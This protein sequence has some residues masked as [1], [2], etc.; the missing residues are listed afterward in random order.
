MTAVLDVYAHCRKQLLEL[1]TTLDESRHETPVPALPLW[2][3]RDT[4]AHLVGNVADA[5][6]GNLAGQGTASWTAAQVADRADRSLADICAEW[7]AN[8]EHFDAELR[9]NPVLWGNAFDLWHHEQDIRAALGEP[10]DRDEAR[11]RFTFDIMAPAATSF[12]PPDTPAVQLAA[13]DLRQEWQLGEGTPSTTVHA[14]GY[15]LAR[16]IAG[17]RSRGQV[18]ALGWDN[19][20][21]HIARMP[22]FEFADDDLIE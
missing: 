4:Y 21:P 20:A 2:T 12:W 1:A 11:L 17:R 10:V 14:S 3:V 7:A 13:D 15:E 5:L 8:A 18:E 22:A 6:A 9:A 16:A 19:P